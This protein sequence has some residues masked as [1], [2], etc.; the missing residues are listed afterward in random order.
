MAVFES[1]LYVCK[2]SFPTG[3]IRE[4]VRAHSPT[5]AKTIALKKF[6]KATGVLVLSELDHQTDHG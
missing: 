1:R 5:T 3:V 6:P 2:I 4:I